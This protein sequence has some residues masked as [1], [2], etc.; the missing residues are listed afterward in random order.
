[1]AREVLNLSGNA[2]LVTGGAGFIGSCLVRRLCSLGIPVVTVDKLTYAGNL[3]SIAGIPPALHRFVQADI[4]DA[5]ALAG[6]F[7][8]YRPA[9]VMHLAAESHV[10]RS[11]DGPAAF[12]QTN[13]VGSF[14][15]LVNTGRVSI[16]LHALLFA[17]FTSPPTR[18]SDHSGTTGGSTRR[19]HTSR[20]RRT[21]RARRLRITSPAHGSIPMVC[22]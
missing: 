17:S 18:C 1:M 19:R 3:D 7:R 21:L 16:L 9:A 2:V 11:I 14:R 6:V 20:G 12:I 8:E 15:L 22:P 5:D 13:C 10:D 4:C